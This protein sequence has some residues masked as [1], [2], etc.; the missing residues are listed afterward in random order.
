MMIDDTSLRFDY[1]FF[2]VP[3]QKVM[4]MVN[5]ISADAFEDQVKAVFNEVYSLRME[6][7]D[8]STEL[9]QEDSQNMK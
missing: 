1:K 2:E 8:L 6:L 9:P 3:L 7:A 4:T 5:R